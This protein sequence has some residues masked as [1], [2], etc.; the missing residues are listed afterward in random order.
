M[1]CKTPHRKLKIEQQESHKNRVEVRCSKMV[2]SSLLTNGT[3][4]VTLVNN[5]MVCHV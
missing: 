4:R 1:I 3:R 5:A 2:G